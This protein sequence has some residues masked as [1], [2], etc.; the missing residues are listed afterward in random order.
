[1]KL[2]L[3]PAMAFRNILKGGA[4]T[5][6]TSCAIQ[7]YVDRKWTLLGDDDGPMYFKTPAERN[8]KMKELQGMEVVKP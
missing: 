1:M 3:R 5:Q 6:Q 7:V 4:V 2:K 8:A